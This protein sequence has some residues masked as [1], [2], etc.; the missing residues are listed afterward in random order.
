DY[1]DELNKKMGK[2]AGGLPTL[3][4]Q[5]AKVKISREHQFRMSLTPLGY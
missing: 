1:V 4:V 3:V 2:S 5:F